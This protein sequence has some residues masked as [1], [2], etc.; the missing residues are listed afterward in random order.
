MRGSLTSNDFMSNHPLSNRELTAIV[1]LPPLA[2]SALAIK[3][4]ETTARPAALPA[5]LVAAPKKR[6]ATADG[7]S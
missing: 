1:V 5:A 2:P 4:S 3:K 7:D 6:E